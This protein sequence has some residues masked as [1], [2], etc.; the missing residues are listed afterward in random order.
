MKGNYTKI[1]YAVGL[2]AL[3]IQLLLLINNVISGTLYTQEIITSGTKLTFW[4]FL[5]TTWYG[6]LGIVLLIAMF[7]LRLKKG[8][9]IFLELSSVFLWVVQIISL[10]SKGMP[11]HSFLLEYLVGII[12]I[13]ILLVTEVFD[14]IVAKKKNNR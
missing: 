2:M 12:G 5:G 9:D 3:V 10:Y 4:G 6:I 7:V 11:L 1:M 13:V 8:Q 14:F